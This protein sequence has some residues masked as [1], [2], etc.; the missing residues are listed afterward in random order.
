MIL[1]ASLFAAF[2]GT[3][4]AANWA[5]ARY[6]IVPIGFGLHAPAG[7]FFAGLA[8]GL[9]DALHE[10]GGHRLILGA[11]AVGAAISY[12][13]ED[14]VTIP[15]GLVPIALASAVAFALSELTDLAVYT[16]LHN[17]AN[18][19]RDVFVPFSP[20]LLGDGYIVERPHTA[21]RWWIAAVV[22]S[23]LV[24]AVV[25]SALFLWLAFGAL[26]HMAGQI[27]GKA[28]M[29]AVALPIVYLARQRRAVPRHTVNAARS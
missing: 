19:T 12:L 9:R 27:V 15:G 7:V 10:V 29:I 24:G 16:P 22:A 1:K 25:D 18:Q 14:A 26:D 23:N 11:I 28:Y 3:V 21:H 8:F 4:I 5:L 20:V 17:K 6:G 2:V 13:I